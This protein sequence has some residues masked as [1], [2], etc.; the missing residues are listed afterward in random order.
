MNPFYG[1]VPV[2][3]PNAKIADILS[4]CPI[5]QPI[6]ELE[7]AAQ[8]ADSSGHLEVPL[9]KEHQL[10]LMKGMSYK[11]PPTRIVSPVSAYGIVDAV[12]NQILSW[13]LRLEKESIVDEGLTFSA[14]EK[15]KA[16]VSHHTTNFHI[17][18]MSQSQ[19]QS[20]SNGSTQTLVAGNL[21]ADD[22]RRLIALIRANVGGLGIADQAR[23]QMEADV[24][25]LEPQLAAP[26][27]NQGVLREG[28]RS[29][30]TTLE[31]A[32]GNLIA[33]GILHQMAR[34]FGSV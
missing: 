31:G 12:R 7:A 23:A 6:G 17:G 8:S 30:R 10:N 33:S 28:L 4:Q 20:A 2:I 5:G 1:Y 27:P 25:T 13:C 11:T 3:I 9:S 34:L 15:Q 21:P 22:I 29:I 19:I 18:H 16:V 14:E 24:A 26:E 32:A